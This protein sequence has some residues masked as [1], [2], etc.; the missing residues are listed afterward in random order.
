[1]AL[2]LAQAISGGATGV[3]LL[4]SP[5]RMPQSFGPA[6]DC[7][8]CV[9]GYLLAAAAQNP[10]FRLRSLNGGR[11]ERLNTADTAGLLFSSNTSAI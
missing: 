4:A 9:S 5:A 7:D 11:N 1:M 8:A 6:I 2:L 10:G 3:F